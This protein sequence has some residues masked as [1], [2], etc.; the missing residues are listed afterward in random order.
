MATENPNTYQLDVGVNAVFEDHWVLDYASKRATQLEALTAL[1]MTID[2]EAQNT[3]LLTEVL[4]IA[5]DLA[6]EM[7]ALVKAVHATGVREGQQAAG[8]S[9]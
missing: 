6:D 7:K 4:W 8:A 1:L 5:N 2:T 3:S 9:Y